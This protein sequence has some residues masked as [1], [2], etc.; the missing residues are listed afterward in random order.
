MSVHV[1]KRKKSL[2]FYMIGTEKFVHR[3]SLRQKELK[4]SID[5]KLIVWKKIK[6][7]RV[8]FTFRF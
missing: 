3:I 2:Y 5:T 6:K 4:Q 7:Y 1:I 8:L